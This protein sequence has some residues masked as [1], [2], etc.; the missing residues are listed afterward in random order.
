VLEGNETAAP[1]SLHCLGHSRARGGDFTVRRRA[2][3]VVSVL[4][5]ELLGSIAY[6]LTACFG[7]KAVI[8]PPASDQAYQF[9][10]NV[11][12][13]IRHADSSSDGWRRVNFTLVC[14]E[15]MH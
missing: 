10:S 8:K 2:L 6:K 9:H 11:S 5:T 1:A 13:S 14:R 7:D 3:D 15:S 12:S 4:V